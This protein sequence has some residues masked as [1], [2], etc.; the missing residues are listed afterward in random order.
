MNFE[1]D[2]I[3]QHIIRKE[4]VQI[5]IGSI[6][7]DG[8]LV[9]LTKKERSRLWLK[10]DDKSY[11][12]L[13][14]L[15]EKLKPFGVGSLKA[16]KGYTQHYFLTYGSVFLGRLR[17]IFYPNGRVKEI[18]T[19]IIDLVQEPIVLAVWYMDDGNLDWRKKY[20]CNPTF[21]TY[22]FSYS[23]CIRLTGMLF[24]NF[25][26]YAKVHKSTMRGKVYFRLYIMS[27]SVDKFF[28][29]IKPF[30]CPCFSYKIGGVRQQ[31]R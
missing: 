28:E 21:A 7:G 23:D 2:D 20:H 24:K 16:K 12:Y 8:F 10:Y 26:I 19:N 3:V 31:P 18:P 6:L 13:Q 22:C 9:P 1:D 5:A 4:H 15:W 29:I 11:I 25:G 14:W 30:I 27:K 17:K